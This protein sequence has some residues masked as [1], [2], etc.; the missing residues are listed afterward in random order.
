M[1]GKSSRFPDLPKDDKDDSRFSKIHGRRRSQHYSDGSSSRHVQGNVP[2]RIEGTCTTE[3][4]EHWNQGK[5][6][7][8]HTV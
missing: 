8:F 3:M 4:I 7:N 5:K 1:K 6:N 2:E